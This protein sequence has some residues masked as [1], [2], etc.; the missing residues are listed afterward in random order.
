VQR[1]GDNVAVTPDTVRAAAAAFE[2]ADAVLV[3]FELP[4]PVIR[5]TILAGSRR[6]ARVVVHPAPPLDDSVGAG[7]LPWDQV[8]VLVPS[9]AE[10][11]ALLGGDLAGRDLAGDSLADALAAELGV[12]T[13]VVTLGESGCVARA[14]GATRGY[15][16]QKTVAVDT[17]GV[18]DAFTAAFVAQP[19][20]GGPVDDAIHAAQSGAAW[21]VGYPGA[22]QSMPS[23]ASGAG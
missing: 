17:T 13:V 15:P 12:P 20:A 7:W 21:A 10:A 14:A 16:A 6:G 9:G 11:R 1:I 3:T 19:T 2:E 22:R 18:S 23:P 5:E 4:V 8:G